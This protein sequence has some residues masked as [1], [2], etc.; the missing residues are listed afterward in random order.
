MPPRLIF[1]PALASTTKV[2]LGH[3]CSSSV[4]FKIYVTVYREWYNKF[5]A[6]GK[7]IEVWSDLPGGGRQRGEWGETPFVEQS[8]TPAQSG[9]STPL[10]DDQSFSFSLLSDNERSSNYAIPQAYNNE[11]KVTLIATFALPQTYSHYSYTFRVAGPGGRVEWLG[12]MG[13]NGV[14]IAG[15]HVGNAQPITPTMEESTATFE[16]EVVA[17]AEPEAEAEVEAEPE[18][19]DGEVVALASPAR[20]TVPLAPESTTGAEEEIT[21]SEVKEGTSTA[22]SEEPSSPA[23]Y[24]S[25]TDIVKINE[26]LVGAPQHFWLGALK[27][28]LTW[29]HVLVGLWAFFLI[30]LGGSP[31]TETAPVESKAVEEDAPTTDAAEPAEEPSTKPETISLDEE[32]APAPV[33]EPVEKT[34]EL[35]LEPKAET[36]AEDGGASEGADE[37]K[38]PVESSKDVLSAHRAILTP[39]MTP[40]HMTANLLV[41]PLSA[42]EMPPPALSHDDQPSSPTDDVTDELNLRTKLVFQLPPN[43]DGK[44]KL[45]LHHHDEESPFGLEQLRLT[46]DRKAVALSSDAETR[47]EVDAQIRRVGGS[48]WIVDVDATNVRT[49]GNVVVS[50]L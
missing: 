21:M 29:V 7:R 13:S 8:K 41:S 48:S 24:P 9:T 20:E 46:V 49:R 32:P 35:E 18:V 47:S 30:R 2:P 11:R 25:T 28:V 38:Y 6:D 5:R 23:A 33:P 1:V 3:A 36:L 31:K 42:V 39:P 15:S 22:A 50:V 16:D 27:V 4:A 45:V 14:V 40:P 43:S 34:E 26:Q 44:F 37:V 19:D 10:N 12:H 17:E